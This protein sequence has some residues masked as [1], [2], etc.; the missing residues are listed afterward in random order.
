[1]NDERIYSR[2]GLLDEESQ[3]LYHNQRARASAREID[4]RRE[5]EIAKVNRER[6]RERD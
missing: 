2:D 3:R 4:G 5:R 1:M 6:E